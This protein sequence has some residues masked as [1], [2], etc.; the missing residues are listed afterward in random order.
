M[1][2]KIPLTVS[3]IARYFGRHRVC[4]HAFADGEYDDN[5]VD[6]AATSQHWHEN[7]RRVQRVDEF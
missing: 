4:S 7:P 6:L 3:S 1:Y 5:A 2:K